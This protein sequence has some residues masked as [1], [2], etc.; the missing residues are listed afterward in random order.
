MKPVRALLPPAFTFYVCVEDLLWW[1]QLLL[2][3]FLYFVDVSEDLAL[4]G[5]EGWVCPRGQ[6]V[7]ISWFPD[8]EQEGL[9]EY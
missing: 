3:V 4:E 2:Q 8:Q 5:E 9:F 1:S 6:V 7:E